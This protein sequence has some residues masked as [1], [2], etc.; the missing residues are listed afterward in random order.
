[1]VCTRR[2]G[3]IAAAAPRCHGAAADPLHDVVRARTEIRNS[4]VYTNTTIVASSVEC[5]M[6]D[7][8]SRY[9]RKGNVVVGS[10]G[11]NGLTFFDCEEQPGRHELDTRGVRT[12]PTDL[13]HRER[14]RVS[15][16]E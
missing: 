10:K 15:E 13:S 1:M 11:Q 4:G 7:G 6:D 5:I 3:A 12:W 9:R 16:R 8:A 2:R 14:M